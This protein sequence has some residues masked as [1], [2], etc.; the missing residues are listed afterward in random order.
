M[1]RLHELLSAHGKALSVGVYPWRHREFAA[2]ADLARLVRWKMQA[3][4]RSFSHVLSLQGKRSR[5]REKFVHLG[6]CHYNTHGNQILADD[7]IEKYR[8]TL[9]STTWDKTT[10]ACSRR[11]SRRP[12]SGGARQS[13]RPVVDQE[14]WIDH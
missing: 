10:S 5:F 4:F 12:G 6:D 7:F 9:P 3:I 1:D 11:Q 13:G 2:N 8:S 14:Q